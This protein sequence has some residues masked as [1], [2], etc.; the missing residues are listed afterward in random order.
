M[1]AVSVVIPT[2]DRQPLLERA[3]ASAL[4]QDG[5]EIEVVVV[6]DGSSDGTAAWLDDVRDPRLVVLRRKR[7][8]GVAAA[9]NL[10]LERATG[11]W[12]AFLDDDDVWSPGKLHAQ[13]AAASAAGAG[14]ALAG[15]VVVDGKLR[16]RGAQRIVAADRFGELLLGHNVVPGGASGVLASTELVRRGGG[17]DAELRIPAD[18]DLWIRLA[19][20][21]PPAG[22]DRP[23]VA[24]V[25][26]GG[27]MTS[28]P[29]GFRRELAHMRGKH[30]APRAAAGV[31]LD[32]RGWG[33]WLSEVQ[34]RSGLRARPALAQARLAVVHR[35]PRHAARAITIALSP[36]WLERR[37]AW[38]VARIPPA[39]LDEAEAWLGRYRGDD[40]AGSA[41]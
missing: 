1:P 15:A 12:V 18:W 32:D 33:E 3:V 31:A 40:S 8:G 10:G 9:R 23:L 17:F 2:R 14:W 27:N 21:G 5:V 7:P 37:D 24:Y 29:R 16:V 28:A 4:A 35:R 25:L 39:W 38:R 19:L 36:G 11:R 6:D 22:I 13:V 20:D 34:R 41:S 26:H 30:A